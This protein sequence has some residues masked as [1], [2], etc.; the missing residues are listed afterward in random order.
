[1]EAPWQP[2]SL[3]YLALNVSVRKLGTQIHWDFLGE[4]YITARGPRLRNDLYCVEWDVKLVYHTIPLR[5]LFEE[6]WL[7]TT[8]YNSRLLLSVIIIIT[9]NKSVTSKAMQYRQ[10]IATRTHIW[11]MELITNSI[12]TIRSIWHNSAA[13]FFA[14]W[15]ISAANLRIMWRHLPTELRN[16]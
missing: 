2:D 12:V 8:T 7:C 16:V 11:R 4:M 13:D 5:F 15:K 6:M 10:D 14:F 9:R 1:M 3:S